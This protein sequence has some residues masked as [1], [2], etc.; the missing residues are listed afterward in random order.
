M[1]KVVV[2]EF[3]NREF[4]TNPIFGDTL[5]GAYGRFNINNTDP[6]D[7]SLVVFGG[8]V[9]V[10]PKYYHEKI[11][12]NTQYPNIKRD[13]YEFD[14]ARWCYHHKVPSL[15]LC[16]GAQLLTILNGGK[17][18]QH[19]TGHTQNHNIYTSDGETIPAN[20]CHHQMMFPWTS[21]RQFKVLAKASPS[22]SSG[23]YGEE[24]GVDIRRSWKLT[25][26]FFDKEFCE[27]DVIWW[28]NALSLCVQGH[29]EWLSISHP[30]VK[31]VNSL[32][33]SLLVPNIP[34]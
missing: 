2:L 17:L 9:D 18:I 29:P 11:G 6:S 28:H 25:R 14:I 20:S 12:V 32:I 5:D 30:Y 15:G 33:D 21:T 31:Y 24:F 3:C 16:R 34:R 7:I 10:D 13:K 8:G 4:I 23:Y 19:I 1:K 22:R 26:E 27:P